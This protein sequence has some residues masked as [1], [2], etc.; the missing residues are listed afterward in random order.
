MS[1][2]ETPTPTIRFTAEATSKLSEVIDNHP[3]AVAG[4]RLEIADRT[5]GQF[6]HLLSMVEEGAAVERDLRVETTGGIDVFVP[7]QD[8]RYVDGVEVHFFDD[9]DGNQGLEFRNPNPIWSDPREFAIQDLFDQHLN[10][11]IA[12]HGGQVRLH[13]VVGRTAYVEFAGGCQ[14]CGMASATLKHGVEATLRQHVPDIEEVTDVTDHASGTN[15]YYK[16][17]PT[18][19]GHAHGAH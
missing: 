13:G 16:P 15:P 3:N 2:V 10:P 8:A 7:P 18:G 14:G 11:Q 9:G 6:R 1:E 4:L 5:G 12:G 19:H 17:A